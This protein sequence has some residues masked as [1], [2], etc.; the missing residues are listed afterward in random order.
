MITYYLKNIKSFIKN[1]E[2]DIVLAVGVIL[3]AFI[4]FGAGRITAFKTPNEP[5]IIEDKGMADIKNSL[6][7]D[8]SQ[9]KELVENYKGK[10]VASK[11]GKV[12]HWPWCPWAQKIKPENQIWF[13]SEEEAKKAGYARDSNFEEQAL[14]DYDLE[15]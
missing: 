11:N 15:I 14:P 9:Q 13:N 8:N 6:G 5:I 3:V 12:Y 4:S 7:Q 2:S 1:H 10:F